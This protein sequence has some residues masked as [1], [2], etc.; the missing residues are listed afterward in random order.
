MKKKV[1]IAMIAASIV[2]AVFAGCGNTQTTVET[3]TVVTEKATETE[4]V[5]VETWDIEVETEAESETESEASYVPT[6]SEVQI[7]KLQEQIDMMNVAY[8]QLEQLDPDF[9][10]LVEASVKV[11]IDTGD[12]GADEAKGLALKAYDLFPDN[13]ENHDQIDMSSKTDEEN[14]GDAYFY[15]MATAMG[16]FCYANQEGF[17]DQ[18]KMVDV[19]HTNWDTINNFVKS[20]VGDVENCSSFDAPFYMTLGYISEIESGAPTVVDILPFDEPIDLGTVSINYY[21]LIDVG[22]ETYIAYLLGDE[23]AETYQIV[24]VLPQDNDYYYTFEE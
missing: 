19:I 17:Q 22:G 11:D 13:Y 21:A 6:A 9:L 20:L 10:N 23:N 12:Y 4:E 7:A 16:F 18:Y 14:I 24:N 5:V 8:E 1:I 15:D 2:S 3:E